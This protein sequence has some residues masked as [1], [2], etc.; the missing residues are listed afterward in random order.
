MVTG[1]N[2]VFLLCLMLMPSAVFADRQADQGHGLVEMQGSIIDTPCAIDVA[3]RNQSIDMSVIPVSQIMRDGQG[4]TRPFTIRLINCVLTPLKPGQPMVSRFSVTFD[5]ATTNDNL[6][7]VSGEGK[8]VGLQIADANGNFADPGQPLA[9]GKLQP[10]NSNLDYTLRLVS[11]RQTL[12][13]G[14]YAAT[15]RFK[16]DYY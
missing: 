13:A 6:F 8:G 10:G 12:R 14:T 1:H 9:G 3:D 7:A 2:S 15:I 5:G 16:L 11:N 4:P